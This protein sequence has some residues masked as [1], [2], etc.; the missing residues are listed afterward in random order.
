MLKKYDFRE[1]CKDLAP[2]VIELW[3]KYNKKFQSPVILQER[4][5]RE[6]IEKLWG[7]AERVVNGKY[8]KGEKEDLESF[9]DKLMDITLC[10][11]KI[12]LCKV[13]GG[14]KTRAHSSCDCPLS[15]NIP[16]LN[17][18]GLTIREIRFEKNQKCKLD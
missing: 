11:Y 3:M 10:K 12:N 8:K 17:W 6:R 16:V 18:L 13:P 14:C 2:L 4:S 15:Q 1:V 5:A 9:L 7:K